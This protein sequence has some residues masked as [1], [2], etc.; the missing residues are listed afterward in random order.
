[1]FLNIESSEILANRKT[2]QSLSLIIFKESA[3]QTF[4][5]I[6]FNLHIY[7]KSYYFYFINEEISRVKRSGTWL[8]LSWLS[9]VRIS[10]TLAL[11]C[12]ASHWILVRVSPAEWSCICLVKNFLILWETSS[13]F[14]YSVRLKHNLNNIYWIYRNV[15]FCL[16]LKLFRHWI[17]STSVKS[18]IYLTSLFNSRS[19]TLVGLHYLGVFFFQSIG[20]FG[21]GFLNTYILFLLLLKKDTTKAKSFYLAG[22]PERCFCFAFMEL[23]CL[24]EHLSSGQ[25]YNCLL[26]DG[27]VTL[28]W[29]WGVGHACLADIGK[30]PF[31]C[32][33]EGKGAVLWE[34]IVVRW[35]NRSLFYN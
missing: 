15:P 8:V 3:L 6:S 19:D 2:C 13:P 27:T 24:R 33:N 10:L 23:S 35:A 22:K 34:G 7:R 16:F 11:I 30:A 32:P 9:H 28:L 18:F 25:G 17:N 31:S 12:K 20:R 14:S 21:K 1:M 29:G 4:Y 26:C 5:V